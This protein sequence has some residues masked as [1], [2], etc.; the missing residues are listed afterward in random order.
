[1]QGFLLESKLEGMPFREEFF[2]DDG[3]SNGNLDA[4]LETLRVFEMDC[5]CSDLSGF[6]EI[7]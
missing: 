5:K 1:M 2:E 6:K 3:S 4:Q 7:D